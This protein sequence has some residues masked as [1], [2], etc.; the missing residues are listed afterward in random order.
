MCKQSVSGDFSLFM[1]VWSQKILHGFS[2]PYTNC[3]LQYHYTEK[4][5]FGIRMLDL[6]TITKQII[7]HH[8][9]ETPLYVRCFV[10]FLTIN[11]F[12]IPNVIGTEQVFMGGGSDDNV[13][14]E[15]I[16]PFSSC[17]HY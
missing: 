9:V 17:L 7:S 1:P 3:Q 5:K 12:D 8:T 6:I 15:F 14:F 2:L 16:L 11:S 4:H 13:V 10:R